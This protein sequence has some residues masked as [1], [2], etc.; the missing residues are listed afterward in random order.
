M[1]DDSEEI[2]FLSKRKKNT[3]TIKCSSFT[4]KKKKAQI[5]SIYFLNAEYNAHT[6]NETK[7]KVAAQ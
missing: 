6:E 4:S 5:K 1:Q 2:F 7:H 3:V